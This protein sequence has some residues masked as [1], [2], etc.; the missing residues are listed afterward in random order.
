MALKD[1]VLISTLLYSQV[2]TL[3]LCLRKKRKL[4]RK[5][6][7]QYKGFPKHE[8]FSPMVAANILAKIVTT[9]DMWFLRVSSGSFAAACTRPASVQQWS[10]CGLTL[11]KLLVVRV[12]WFHTHSCIVPPVF[13]IFDIYYHLSSGP[14]VHRRRLILAQTDR[15]PTPKFPQI[16]PQSHLHRMEMINSTTVHSLHLILLHYQVCFQTLLALF[17]TVAVC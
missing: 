13:K 12:V 11:A 8:H 4:R 5:I 16:P 10:G 17:F 3:I 2:F 1:H 9:L 15:V 14:Q 6:A 7:P